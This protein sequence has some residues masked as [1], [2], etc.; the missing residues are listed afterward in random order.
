[1]TYTSPSH[2]NQAALRGGMARGKGSAPPVICHR[3]VATRLNGLAPALLRRGTAIIA[4]R[5]PMT[6][7]RGATGRAF[8]L[9]NRAS[10]P[11]TNVG[12]LR[13]AWLGMRSDGAADTRALSRSGK[14]LAAG[15]GAS[16]VK[17]LTGVLRA[18][19]CASPT[20]TGP[21]RPLKPCMNGLPAHAPVTLDRRHRPLRLHICTTG[22]GLEKL[23]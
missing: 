2:P 8:C 16:V 5:R 10:H 6:E 14:A 11:S 4:V 9:P 15:A 12:L 22:A 23:H 13:R 21:L 17:G 18:S 3:M 19:R 7:G 20:E 1:M